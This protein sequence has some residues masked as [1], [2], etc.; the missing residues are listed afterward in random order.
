MFGS[1]HA[2]PKE[3]LQR[4]V[5]SIKYTPGKPF[6]T[7]HLAQIVHRRFPY[8]L[9]NMCVTFCI[10]FLRYRLPPDQVPGVALPW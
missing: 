3:R 4:L 10:Q 5:L 8:G 9:V 6:S 7:E 1:K 2:I